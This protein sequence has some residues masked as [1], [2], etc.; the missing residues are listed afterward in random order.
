MPASRETPNFKLP[1]YNGSDH[2]S[3]LT[4]FNGAMGTIDR[5][6]GETSEASKSASREATSALTPGPCRGGRQP[7]HRA[8]R[9]RPGPQV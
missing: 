3:V 9:R 8:H 1:L 2:F 7:R 4:D 6:L 5:I